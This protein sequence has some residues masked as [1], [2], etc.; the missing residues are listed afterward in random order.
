MKRKVDITFN[1]GVY[2]VVLYTIYNPAH[3]YSETKKV[4]TRKEAEKIKKEFLTKEVK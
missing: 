3:S 2:E 4:K 1:Y